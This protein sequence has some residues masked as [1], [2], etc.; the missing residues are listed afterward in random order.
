M[1]K[2]LQL[3]KWGRF[4]YFFDTVTIRLCFLLFWA[5]VLSLTNILGRFCLHVITTRQKYNTGPFVFA[6]KATH[7]R[8]NIMESN[9]CAGITEAYHCATAQN[10]TFCTHC[11]CCTWCDLLRLRV[12][13]SPLN[14]IGQE[15]AHI[16]TLK[17]QRTLHL[18]WKVNF[19]MNVL[20][21]YFICLV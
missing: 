4:V 20:S 17:R 15:L 5:V 12:W 13:A 8:T 18:G 11:V 1:V 16:T 3:N 19:G 10:F 7:K 14:S 21:L 2:S 9:G 6:W